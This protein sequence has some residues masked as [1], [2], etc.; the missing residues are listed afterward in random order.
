MFVCAWFYFA[1]EGHG[2][3]AVAA[4]AFLFFEHAAIGAYESAASDNFFSSVF[5]IHEISPFSGHRL[6]SVPID[7]NHSQAMIAPAI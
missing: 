3:I 7:R 1:V 6:L 5:C 4:L 2:F